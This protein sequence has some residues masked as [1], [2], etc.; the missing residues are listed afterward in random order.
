MDN[1]AAPSVI[2]WYGPFRDF[3]AARRAV[4]E[5]VARVE[6]SAIGLY[7]VV[8]QPANGA[9]RRWFWWLLRKRIA[10]VGIG[11]LQRRLNPKHHA[12]KN[13]REP[14]VWI[15]W[16]R[17]LPTPRERWEGAKHDPKL[18][19]AEWAHAL[20]LRADLNRKKRRT[21]PPRRILVQNAWHSPAIS[22]SRTPSPFSDWPDLMVWPAADPTP[23]PHPKH[24]ALVWLAP[25]LAVRLRDAHAMMLPTRSN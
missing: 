5:N 18:D 10:Y 15:G 1:T 8:G 13:I 12:L 6:D 11:V 23:Q 21:L 25:L 19:D 22:T 20:F 2:D 17:S 9:L 4:R 16:L 14:A 24:V 7:L 3:E